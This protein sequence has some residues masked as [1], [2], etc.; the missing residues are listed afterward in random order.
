LVVRDFDG[1]GDPDV[2][3]VG[4]RQDAVT[5]LRNC[6]TT[7]IVTCAGDGSSIACPCGNSSAAGSG[8]GCTNSLGIAGTLRAAGWASFVRDGVIL[9]ATGTPDGSAVYMQ[10]TQLV[11][12]GAGIGFGDGMRCIGGNIVRLGIRDANGHASSL[13]GIG[14]PPLSILGGI[15][16]AGTRH[17]QVWY[18]NS[19][20]FCT[21]SAFNLTNGLSVV[22]SN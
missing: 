21:P 19:A 13:P 5:V 16:G 22:W 3:A 8:A 4:T 15:A 14:D 10:G 9:Q 6:S 18:R 2:A 1:D 12:G 7:G 20:A 17:Y 11:A